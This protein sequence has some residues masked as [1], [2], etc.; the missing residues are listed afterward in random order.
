MVAVGLMSTTLAS[1]AILPAAIMSPEVMGP[2]MAT[3]L[4]TSISF[5]T[6][7]T[8]SAGESFSFSTMR[9]TLRPLMPPALFT[10][11]TAISTPR[12]A[13]MPSSAPM[14]RR[15]TVP[16]LM[17]GSAAPQARPAVAI[18]RTLTN[19]KIL[20]KPIIM[21]LLISNLKFVKQG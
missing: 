2:M 17:G 10:S 11:S 18:S 1:L 19:T 7:L 20:R 16:S 12:R 6:A 21:L 13:G 9:S 15:S 3:T 14:D 4:S 8:A 5:F